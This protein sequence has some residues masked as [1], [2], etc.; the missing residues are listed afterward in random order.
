MEENRVKR[1]LAE[2]GCAFGTMVFEFNTPGMAR[3]TAAAGADFAVV[4]MEHT[5]WSVETLRTM[6]ATA[7]AAELV[8]AVRSSST[9][10]VG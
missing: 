2:G 6:V 10:L 5:G 1:T 4:D 8:R 7:R 3:L 9:C